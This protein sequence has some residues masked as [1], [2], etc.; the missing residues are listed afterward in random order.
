M[1]TTLTSTGITF[2]DGTTQTTA[3][4]A[5]LGYGQTY[6]NVTSSRALSTTYYNTTGKPITVS[7]LSSFHYGPLL[8][9]YVN[10]TLIQRTLPNIGW[11]TQN[12]QEYSFLYF[13]VPPGSNYQVT[14]NTSFAYWF[15]LR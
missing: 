6:Q 4:S 12:P 5:G 3:P 2:P 9:G 15:E 11:S 8:Q 14:C 1:A 13:I 7:V 10:G